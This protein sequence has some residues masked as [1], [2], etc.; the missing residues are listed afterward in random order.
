MSLEADEI[1]RVLMAERNKLVAYA[2]SILGDFNMGED[3]VQEVALLAMAKGGERADR[4][5]LTVWL[6]RATRLKSLEALRQ[7]KRT[8]AILSEEALDKLEPHWAAYDQQSDLAEPAMAEMLRACFQ[9]LTHNQ[10][11]LLTLRYA[12]GLRSSEIAERLDMNVETVYRA[13]TRAH[14]SLADCV[15]SKLGAQ[16]KA[17]TDD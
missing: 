6:R 15:Q 14:R 17:G 5:R 13:L 1:I 16:R 12:D 2:W 3:V 7:K 10:R 4:P 11:R 8:G 9:G